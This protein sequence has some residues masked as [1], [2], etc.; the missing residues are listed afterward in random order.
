MK[1]ASMLKM[2]K[3]VA[4]LV[5]SIAVAATMSAWADSSALAARHP[6]HQRTTIKPYQGYG[7][8]VRRMNMGTTSTPRQNAADDFC[9]LPS[10]GC[11]SF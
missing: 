11:A 4:L 5:I 6:W 3:S 9:G 10:S 8:D 2:K 7:G 1:D